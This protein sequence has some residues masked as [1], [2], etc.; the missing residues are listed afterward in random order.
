GWHD[1]VDLK[2]ADKLRGQ[3]AEKNLR[4]NTADRRGNGLD[5]AVQ[6]RARSQRPRGQSRLHRALTGGVND[7]SLTAGHRIAGGVERA[8]LVL[9]NTLGGP[10]TYKDAGL[11]RADRYGDRRAAG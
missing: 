3:A 9:N 5:G 10:R 8:I 6:G 7:H 1:H 4:R 2:E 11:G